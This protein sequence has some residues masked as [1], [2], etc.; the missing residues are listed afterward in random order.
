MEQ[1]TVMLYTRRWSLRCWRIRRL[2]ARRGY[3]FEVVDT[4]DGGLRASLKRLSWNAHREAAPYVFVDHRP[5]G[6]F[7]D[8]QA[9]HYSGDLERLVRGEV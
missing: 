8:I 5:V 4:A 9:L 7:K 3:H 2:L 6:G 1:R